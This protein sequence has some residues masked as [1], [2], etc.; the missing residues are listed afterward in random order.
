[1]ATICPASTIPAIHPVVT[2]SPEATLGT[3]LHHLAAPMVLGQHLEAAGV[4]ALFHVDAGELE[5]LARC[6]WN[7][8]AQL[9]D[10]FPAPMVEEPLELT[11]ASGPKLTGRVDLL[12]LVYAAEGNLW[13]RDMPSEARVLDW[14]TNRDVEADYAAQLKGYAYL[15]CRRWPSIQR[16]YTVVAWVRDQSWDAEYH[17]RDSLEH[18]WMDFSRRLEREPLPYN[19]GLSCRYCPRALECPARMAMLEQA[20][21]LVLASTISGQSSDY[22]RLWMMAQSLQGEL[23]KVLKMVRAQVAIHGGSLPAGAGYELRLVEQERRMILARQGMAPL[24]YAIG[25]ERLYDCITIH[26][27][28]VEAVVRE[29]VPEDAPR[30][31]KKRAVEDLHQRLEEAEAFAVTKVERLELKRIPNQLEVTP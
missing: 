1:L 18:W 27:T 22:G 25:M 6:A 28:K 14:K 2:S 16:V 24:L 19:P 7:V 12:S 21:G 4:A 3:A 26:K 15:A 31:E 10:K 29:R 11:Q 9:R 30:G 5:I 17:T 23:E 13:S 8:W 20:M